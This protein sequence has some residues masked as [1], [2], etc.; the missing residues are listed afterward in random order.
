M[1]Y[2][3]HDV[4][5]VD[6]DPDKIR[7]L[8][9]GISPIHETGAQELLNQTTESICF[10]DDLANAVADSEVIMIAVGTPPKQNGEADTRYVE[11]AARQV[12]C[13]LEQNREYVIVIK[14]TVPIGTNRRIAHL[15][16]SALRERDVKTNVY[17]ASNPE[18]LQEGLAL[19]GTFYPDRV[20][21]GADRT[22]AVDVIRR[23]HEPI[24]QRTF[25]PP[26]FL[27]APDDENLPPLIATDATNAEM[28]KYAANTFLALKISFI[29]EIAGLCERVEADVTEVARG[30]GL[31]SRISHR[32]LK[33]GVG[34]GGSCF[35]KDTDALLRVAS[36]YGYSM[37]IIEAAREINQRQRT[38]IVEKLQH[39]LKILRGRTIGI[40][41]LAFK[42]NTDDVRGSPALEIIQLLDEQ[43]AYVRAHDPVAIPYARQ[44]L[45]DIEVEYVEDAYAVSTHADAVVLVTD[46]DEYRALNLHVLARSM[47]TPI[48]I[49]GR[50]VYSP[51]EA[52]EAGFRYM[53]I[54]RG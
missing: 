5:G 23:L 27:A 42:P 26:S 29:N 28:I 21:V 39:A 41:G 15:V 2:L 38:L 33:A 9:Q 14:S 37:P 7:L 36:E 40:L 30:V 10:T 25:E 32:F 44:G 52:R 45:G 11:E 3:K 6:K 17:F 50:N 54:G 18:F 43:G 4:V 34:W 31:D 8:R 13:G 48:L 35:P 1:A 46:W 51:D 16:N 47:N 19:R 49:D 12:A 22:E 20:V 24:L 53:G